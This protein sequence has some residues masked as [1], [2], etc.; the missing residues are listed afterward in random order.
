MNNQNL[1]LFFVLL[2]FKVSA[3]K[4]SFVVPDSLKDKNYE[5]LDN[6]F[7]NLKRDSTKAALYAYTFLLKAKKEGNSKEILNGFQNLMLISPDNLRIVYADSMLY[8]AKKSN[9]NVLIGS[10]YLTKGSVYYG[11]KQQ[12]KALDNYLTANRFL[13]KT[14]DLYQIHKVKY[15]IALA[16][17]YVGFYEESVSLLRECVHFYKNE[18]SRAYLNSI[19]LL[20][21]CY[22]KLGN[23]G[24]C[25]EMNALGIAESKRLNSQEMLPYFTHSEGINDFFKKN[26]SESI[27]NIE[28]S[29]EAIKENSDFANVA[30]GNFYIGKSYWSQNRKEKAVEHFQIIDNIF[31]EKKYLRPDLR[32]TFELMI[33]YYKSK[34]NLSAQLYYVDELLRADTLLVENNKYILGKIHKQYDTQELI[35]EKERI[36][37][38]LVWEKNYD[39]IFTFVIFI[40]FA[41]I[42]YLNYRY[43]RNKKLYKKNFEMLMQEHKDF[44]NTTKSKLEKVPIKDINSETVASILKQL[45]KFENDKKFLDKDWNLVTLSA[46]FNSNTK[47][48]AAIL[49]HYRSKGINEYING[50]RIDYIINLLQSE[51]KF[52]KYSYEALAQEAGFSSTQRF[53]NAFQVKAGMPVSFFIKEITKSSP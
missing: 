43:R 46:A 7:Y 42:F 34:K 47:Y 15:C 4:V 10:A 17:F 32:Q 21:L 36:S 33:D 2:F 25:S 53:A 40:L 39:V 49:Y 13:S 44:K 23:Y 26:Y 35:S 51:S 8:A 52:R 38:E 12:Q 37:K 11:L 48:L 9:D 41:V 50:L 24:L 14:N 31:K 5:Y 29:L 45:E 28:S 19:H 6:K 30:I 18:D 16:K 27:K 20:G 1:L 22:N 3:Q